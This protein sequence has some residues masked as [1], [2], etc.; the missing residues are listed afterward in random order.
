MVTVSLRLSELPV[1]AKKGSFGELLSALE[2]IVRRPAD[3]MGDVDIS[4]LVVNIYGLP[5]VCRP[6]KCS[7]FCE[8]CVVGR[9]LSK[10]PV[11]PLV[12]QLGLC[13][14][15]AVQNRSGLAVVACLPACSPIRFPAVSLQYLSKIKV[16]QIEKDR[17]EWDSL[18][19]EARREKESSLQMFGQLARFHNIMSNETIGTLAFLTSGRESNPPSCLPGPGEGPCLG[20]GGRELGF[21]VV[22]AGRDCCEA[23]GTVGFC[24]RN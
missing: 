22:R 8:T 5:T 16:Q 19:Q 17:G 18:S 4:H 23:Q 12:S 14:P 20:A 2:L 10:H 7:M 21:R 24:S 3:K 13:Q 1:A 6:N 9:G 15:G 11:V